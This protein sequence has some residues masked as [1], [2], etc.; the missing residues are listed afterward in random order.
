MVTKL[1]REK[2]FLNYI[3]L[4]AAR[5]DLH[6]FKHCA[7]GTFLVTSLFLRPYVNRKNSVFIVFIVGC[8]LQ[9]FALGN[10]ERGES[11]IRFISLQ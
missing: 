6:G 4:N 1:E 5:Q 7:D 2:I 11:D 3:I 9:F 10:I 8:V